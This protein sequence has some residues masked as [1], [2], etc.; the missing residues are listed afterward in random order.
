MQESQVVFVVT[1]IAVFAA[2][3]LCGIGA[4]LWVLRDEDELQ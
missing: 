2:F 1:F 3:M 4:L